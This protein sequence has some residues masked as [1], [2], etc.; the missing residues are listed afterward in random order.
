MMLFVAIDV[1][2][3]LNCT[4]LFL[5]ADEKFSL[6]YLLVSLEGTCYCVLL[7]VVG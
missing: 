4:M 3:F 1:F 6:G 2:V 5:I 7:F